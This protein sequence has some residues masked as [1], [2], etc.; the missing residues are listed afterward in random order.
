MSKM[1]TLPTKVKLTYAQEQALV[2]A[3]VAFMRF[4]PFFCHYF[5]EVLEEYPTLDLPTL[6][7]DGK[8][9]FINPDYILTLDPVEVAF[10]LAHETYHCVR[11]HP[12]RSRHYRLE[13][14]IKGLPY[15]H[16]LFNIAEDYTIN[17]DLVDNKIGAIHQAGS[18]T[19]TSRP[20]GCPRMS[21][22]NFTTTRPPQGAGQKPARA[23][24]LSGGPAGETGLHS[25]PAGRAAT[26]KPNKTYRDIQK[27]TRHDKRR[28]RGRRC[29]RHDDLNPSGTR[30]PVGGCPRRHGVQ[31][32][33]CA[34]AAGR[35]RWA[36][37][38]ATCSG[39]SMRSL[40][41]QIDWKEHL[42]MLVTGKIR[43]PSGGWARPNRRR[44]VLSPI[45]IL[46][47]QRG[48]GSNLRGLR[49]G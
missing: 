4:C 27:S 32:R 46:P 1:E 25:P 33:R 42:R 10:A 39:W 2:A 29:V 28:R 44:L 20:T 7:T 26:L 3:R 12:Q 18:T 37:C 34:R 49:R 47:G 23:A 36:T 15:D 24:G 9:V 16:T 13:G 8:R 21:T 35:R 6:A 45:V 38:P 11:S 40:E 5:Y 43:Q 48:H 41:P 30:S 31:G 22:S 19:G 14:N 17:A